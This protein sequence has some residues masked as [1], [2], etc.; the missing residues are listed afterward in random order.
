MPQFTAPGFKP[1]TLECNAM[2]DKN[3]CFHQ[4]IYNS[5]ESNMF[6]WN[7]NYSYNNKQQA[8]G[9]TWIPHI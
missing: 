8:H 2:S 4:I 7:E 3:Y 1:T 9:I 6:D 5:I